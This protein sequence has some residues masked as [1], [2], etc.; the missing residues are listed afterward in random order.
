MYDFL[1]WLQIWLIHTVALTFELWPPKLNQLI[2][3]SNWMIGKFRNIA[4]TRMGPKDGQTSW[5]HLCPWHPKNVLKFPAMVGF[6]KYCCALWNI[7]VLCKLLRIFETYFL[8]V[9]KVFKIVCGV[10]QW[11]RFLFI[12]FCCLIVNGSNNPFLVFIIS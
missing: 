1:S 2:L 7:F 6:L 4:F 8:E 10:L 9:L 3:Q 11:Y 5:K 12:H